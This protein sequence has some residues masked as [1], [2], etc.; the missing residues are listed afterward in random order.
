[1]D[2]SLRLD[3][4]KI[5]VAAQHVPRCFAP[6]FDEGRLQL[7]DDW[8]L[9]SCVRIAPMVV[10]SAVAGPCFADAVTSRK[11]DFSVDNQ[12][13]AVI[14]MIVAQQLPRRDELQYLDASKP[15]HAAAGL[16]PQ[17]GYI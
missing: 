10:G 14:A 7:V 2:V 15:F 5:V 4:G 11:A 9:G 8:T 13:A 12:N 3:H 1:M 16:E 17:L 6:A